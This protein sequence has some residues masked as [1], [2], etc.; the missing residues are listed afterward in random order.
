MLA[1]SPAGQKTHWADPTR[2]VIDPRAQ[3]MQAEAPASE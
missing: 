3:V 2:L 1:Y